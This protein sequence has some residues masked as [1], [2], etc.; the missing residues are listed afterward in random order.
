MA[1]AVG[2][3]RVVAAHVL[4]DVVGTEEVGVPTEEVL[5][6]KIGGLPIGGFVAKGLHLGPQGFIEEWQ[7]LAQR[8]D[9]LVPRSEAEE[10]VVRRTR[11]VLEGLGGLE[12]GL[13][14]RVEL[15]QGLLA[16]GV[17]AGA[18]LQHLVRVSSRA[19]T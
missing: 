1:E 4:G 15:R 8:E 5:G 9:L 16:R 12:D 14:L 3:G 6:D 19:A 7:G 18:D 17:L 10:L 2:P 13:R 11:K